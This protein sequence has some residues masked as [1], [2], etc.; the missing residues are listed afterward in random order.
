MV[1]NGSTLSDCNLLSLSPDC[2]WFSQNL[3]L[4]ILQNGKSLSSDC[5]LSLSLGLQMD[6]LTISCTVLSIL[7]MVLNII[8]LSRIENGSL[9]IS[10]SDCKWFSHNL[11]L[12]LGLQMVLSQ[13][14]SLSRLQMVLSQSSISSDCKW[15]S[16]Q[17]LSRIANGSLTISLSPQIANGS[18]KSL[19]IA[20]GSLTISK[21]FSQMVLSTKSLSLSR[22]QMVLLSLSD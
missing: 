14:L 7:Q 8:S 4:S 20:N 18:L 19:R 1:L 11:S 3:S 21:W 5:N 6:S 10:L 12:S 13:S 2:K 22:L 9:T 16:L 15:F 17:S